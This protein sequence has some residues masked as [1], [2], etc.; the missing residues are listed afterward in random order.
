M[1]YLKVDKK[2]VIN[3]LSKD[4]KDLEDKVI[5]IDKKL[6]SKNEKFTGWI[7]LPINYDKEEFARIKKAADK[8]K[9]NGKVLVVI[10]IGGSY[11]GAKA[12]LEYLKGYSNPSHEIIFAGFNMSTNYL[13]KLI[14]YL[15][16]VD[17]SINVISKSGTT[18]EP[19]LTFRIL[20]NLLIEKYGLTDAKDRIF[21]T[22]DKEKG[23]LKELA[24]K[25]GYETFILPDNIGGRYSV[26]TP[27]GLLPIAV[28]GY[29]IN[30]I[31]HGANHAYKH[32]SLTSLDENEAYLYAVLRYLLSKDKKIEM[33]VSYE[34]ELRYIA[35]WH[36][37]LFAESEG[38]EGK[39]ILPID[40]NFSTDLHSIG[41]FIQQGSPIMFETILKVE[42][43]NKDI[44]IPFDPNDIDKLNYLSGKTLS[45]INDKAFLG[46][47]DAHVKGGVPNI[48]IE[49]PD[50]SPYS[51]GYLF[52]FFMIACAI[53]A[54]LLKVDPFNQPGVEAYKK[55]M[56]KLLGK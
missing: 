18:L 14:N 56:F 6:R 52:Y 2:N 13:M 20:R 4:P 9:K 26:L 49:I 24:N 29:N 34:Y 7:D 40:V 53:S 41:Q 36:Q 35:K 46:T 38:K 19:S 42:K 3:F 1:S 17:F 16:R 37:Q 27:V 11:L 44:K 32:Y 21:I 30:D 50:I 33:I 47:L 28:A 55:N 48:I 12:S 23:N 5:K 22:T 8:I 45:Y 15:T 31:M 39:G 25:E 43:L 10:G 51:L 54:N